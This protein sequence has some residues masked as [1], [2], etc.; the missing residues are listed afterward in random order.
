[1]RNLVGFRDS[2]VVNQKTLLKSEVHGPWTLE[3]R[4]FC[5]IYLD[6]KRYSWEGG[7]DLL[8]GLNGTVGRFHVC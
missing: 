8:A 3:T 4:S 1:M 7:I 2:T 6:R 5:S